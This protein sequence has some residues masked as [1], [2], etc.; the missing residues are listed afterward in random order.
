[1]RASIPEKSNEAKESLNDP[2]EKTIEAEEEDAKNCRHQHN[3]NRCHHGF[4]TRRPDDPCGFGAHFADKLTWTDF[5]QNLIPI[6][7]SPKMAI[8]G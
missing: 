4:T 6:L 8:T 1:M 5:R 2:T 3:H 7:T